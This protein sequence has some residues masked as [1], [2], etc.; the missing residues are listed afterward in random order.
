MTVRELKL[1]ITEAWRCQAPKEGTQ[2]G[3]A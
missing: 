3:R 2:Q 1:L